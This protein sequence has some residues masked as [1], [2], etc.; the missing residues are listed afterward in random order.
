M[1]LKM[2]VLK[3]KP[4]AESLGVNVVMVAFDNL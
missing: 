2:A 1:Q 4:A 3:D